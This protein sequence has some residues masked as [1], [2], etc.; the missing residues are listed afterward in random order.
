MVNLSKDDGGSVVCSP[1]ADALPI[2]GFVMYI[3]SGREL[4]K[5]ISKSRAYF[6][7]T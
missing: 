5:V 1:G 7:F 2:V 3:F 6:L 4:S